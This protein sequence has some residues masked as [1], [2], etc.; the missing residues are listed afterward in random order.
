MGSL[1]SLALMAAVAERR[2]TKTLADINEKLRKGEPYRP[3]TGKVTAKA[4]GGAAK[5]EKRG[6]AGDAAREAKRKE[7]QAAVAAAMKLRELEGG[8]QASG[9]TKLTKAHLQ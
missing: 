7:V 3:S 4:T 8:K 9:G 1:F 2:Q 5:R 6:D